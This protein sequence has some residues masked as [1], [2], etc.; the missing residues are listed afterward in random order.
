[1][2]AQASDGGMLPEQVWDGPD[3]PELELYNGRASGSAMP[4][5]WAHAEYAKLVRSLHDGRVYDMPQ[6]PYERYVRTR[7]V[8]TVTVWAPHNR[9]QSLQAGR[10]LRIQT[11]VAATI[12]WSV[13]GET[14]TREVATIDTTLPGVFVADLDTV[15]LLAGTTVRFSIQA[16]DGSVDKGEALVAVTA[17]S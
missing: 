4:L 13:V 2:R 9:S 14:T 17:R 5:V 15:G 10:T 3:I 12:R 6:Q 16:A 7:R 1:M 8:A 11:P